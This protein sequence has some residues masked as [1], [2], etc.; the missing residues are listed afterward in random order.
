MEATR[1]YWG[2]YIYMYNGFI[3]MMEK[4]MET[5]ISGLGFI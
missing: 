4:K 3:G 1:L 5:N 2:I